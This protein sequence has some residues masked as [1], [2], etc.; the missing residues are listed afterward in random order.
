M[1][2]MEN[3]TMGVRKEPLVDDATL[4]R[5]MAQ[6]DVEGLELL[7]PDGVW[8]ELTSR[9]MNRVLEA[10]RT[11]HLGCETGDPVGRGADNICNGYSDKTVLTD[12]GAVPLKVPRDRNGTYEPTLVCEAST[13][14]E[15][16]QRCRDL[17]G[18]LGYKHPRRSSPS[19]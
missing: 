6:I 19:R 16:V 3:D 9:I 18:G 15:R 17:V 2:V 11:D 12:A 8:T 13:S 4:D 5:L 14:V 7:G 10:E 1:K